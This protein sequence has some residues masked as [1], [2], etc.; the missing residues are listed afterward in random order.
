MQHLIFITSGD[1]GEPNED[2]VKELLE[3][4][5]LRSS[6]DECD[7]PFCQGRRDGKLGVDPSKLPVTGRVPDTSSIDPA[8]VT[9]DTYTAPPASGFA[10]PRYGVRLTH[11][12]TGL[13]VQHEGERSQFAN[14]AKAWEALEVQVSQMEFDRKVGIGE[15][16]KKLEA[17]LD[18]ALDKFVSDLVG[19]VMTSGSEG[20]VWQ[21]LVKRG[22]TPPGETNIIYPEVKRNDGGYTA[23]GVAHIRG[24]NEC[25]IATMHLNR[26]S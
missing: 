9:V 5:G 17:N 3:A 20:R 18:E 7:C 4:L 10:Q 23:E 8:D 6:D 24:W 11:K 25:R 21:E 26:K 13:R 16:M 12:P 19:S 14:K 15:Q 1:A 22:W 2:R